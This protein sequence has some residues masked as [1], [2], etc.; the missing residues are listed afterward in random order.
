M[1]IASLYVIVSFSYAFN[2]MLL[3][4]WY[5]ATLCVVLVS[6]LLRARP[7]LSTGPAVRPLDLEIQQ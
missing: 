3:G 4:D 5:I 1:I 2:L 7:A 6:L